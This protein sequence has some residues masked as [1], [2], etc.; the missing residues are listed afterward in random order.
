MSRRVL[1]VILSAVLIMTMIPF[2]SHASSTSK[3]PFISGTYTH[4][5]IA[6]GLNIHH[7]VDVS[8][9]Q[10]KINW[11]KAK[12]DGVEYAII[13]VGC[14]RLVSGNFKEDD[15]FYQNM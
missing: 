7:G 14:R 3:S 11:K 4:S 13:R 9:H 6:D 5:D 2:V 12:K 8:E 15:W 1:A 10:G